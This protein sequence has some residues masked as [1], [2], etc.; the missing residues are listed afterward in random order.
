MYYTSY[1]F[2]CTCESGTCTEPTKKTLL[3]ELEQVDR[4]GIYSLLIKFLNI[5]VTIW[6]DSVSCVLFYMYL[7]MD[8]KYSWSFPPQQVLALGRWLSV[9]ICQIATLY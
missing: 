6:Q 9:H 4:V 8:R 7:V 5:H 1:K 3:L 2:P